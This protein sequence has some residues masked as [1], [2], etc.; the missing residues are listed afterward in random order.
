MKAEIIAVGTEILLGDIVN[1]NAQYL[2]KQLADMGIFVYHQ[3]VV[4]D[5]PQRL[6]KAYQ[7]AFDRVNLV[8]TTGG[9]GPTKDD[10]TKEIA[11]AYFKKELVL[12]KSALEQI[13]E[14]FIHRKR[15]MAKGNIKQAY[16]P[17]GAHLL[18]NPNG[19]APGC[20]V[21]ADKKILILLP[22]PP[23]EMIPMFESS[24]VPYLSQFQ[25]GILYSKV[26]RVCGIGESDMEEKIKDIIEEQSNPTI[27]PY[28]KEG[29][30]TIRLTA[31]AENQQEAE[32]L[33]APLELEINKRLDSHVYGEGA[34]SLEE[35]VGKFLISNNL[36]IA[37][38][39]SCTGG[40]LAGRLINYPGISMAFKEGIVAY[41]NESKQRLLGVKEK[42]L[43]KYGAVS[44]E[45]AREMVRGVAKLA[46]VDTAISITGIA[47]PGGASKE[48]PVGLMYLGI[49]IKGRID[50]KK[51]FFK[52]SR[53]R[54]RNY[55]VNQA[56]CC[57]R[58]ILIDEGYKI[59]ETV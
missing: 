44:E 31:K 38:A 26:L 28:A 23:R 45:T 2:A 42:T 47:G 58:R 57:F 9:L 11:A 52:G 56:L 51:L 30:V 29:E 41:N 8:I 35:V 40:L 20:I 36:T 7:A 12:D 46:K 27:A 6:E 32:A 54:I 50:V 21:E 15:K 4:G 17:Q 18:E 19:T 43:I 34:S 14:Y 5:N 25:D 3:T 49:Y 37:T 13:E 22:G 39:E 53:Q 1:T 48:K 33:I 59:E 16:F 55:G 24:V 10:L